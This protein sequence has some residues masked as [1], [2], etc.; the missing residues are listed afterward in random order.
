MLTSSR[1]PTVFRHKLIVDMK[2]EVVGDETSSLASS[3][4]LLTLIFSGIVGF[5]AKW[6]VLTTHFGS[7]FTA[8]LIRGSHRKV[9]ANY[10]ASVQAQTAG[11][12]HHVLNHVPHS[13]QP[14]QG[15]KIYNQTTKTWAPV[16]GEITPTHYRKDLLIWKRMLK[17][18]FVTGTS[19]WS[20]LSERNAEEW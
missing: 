3:R 13:D 17:L 4:K 15:S 1:D 18:L 20:L 16:S 10:A 8:N 5:L 2:L 6:S 12:S 11:H 9:P 14:K 7:I 19:F